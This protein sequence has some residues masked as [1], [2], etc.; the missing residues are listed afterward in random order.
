[1]FGGFA[2]GILSGLDAIDP[3]VL[4]VAIA[5]CAAY[6]AIRVMSKTLWTGARRR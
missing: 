5:I 1:M 6:L 2:L 3:V 4:L